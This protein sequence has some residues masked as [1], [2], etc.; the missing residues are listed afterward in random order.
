MARPYDKMLSDLIGEL[1]TRGGDAFR[2]RWARHDV[3]RHRAG[4]KRIHHPLAGDL[5]FT[6]ETTRLTADD[7]LHLILCSVPPGSRDAE[8][9]DLVT[10]WNAPAPAPSSSGT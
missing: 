1:S 5:T 4:A 6:Y 10:S 9:L 2:Q 8:G 7:G 3:R